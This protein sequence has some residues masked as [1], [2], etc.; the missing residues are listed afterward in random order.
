MRI[1][2]LD[3]EVVAR[4]LVPCGR[5]DSFGTPEMEAA[6]VETLPLADG[7]ERELVAVVPDEEHARRERLVVDARVQPVAVT[8]DGE[9]TPGAREGLAAPAV[10]LAAVHE[11]GVHP[12]RDVV[13]EDAVGDPA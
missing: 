4:A 12:E 11:P 3:R 10:A 13:Q 1:A 6:L 5:Q 7:E 2:E 8:R 9:Q